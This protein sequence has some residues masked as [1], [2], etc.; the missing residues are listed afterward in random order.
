[1]TS[2]SK[3]QISEPRIVVYSDTEF[4]ETGFQLPGREATK[5]RWDRIFRVAM[6]YEIHPVAVADWDYW[7]FQ[8]GD[9]NLIIWV[10]TND[11]EQSKQFSKEVE[12]RFGKIDVPPMK[13]WIDSDQNIRT[14][15]IWPK[16]DIGE[17]LYL[18]KKKHK[19]SLKGHLVH[20]NI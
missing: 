17:S 10:R 7:A 5:I 19:W 1:M 6:C 16:A 4:D 14:Y 15:V 20:R 18:T 9:P 13:D 11:A 12:R 8:T 2:K 3:D